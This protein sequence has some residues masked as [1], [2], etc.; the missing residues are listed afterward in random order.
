[1]IL[2]GIK[3]KPRKAQVMPNGSQT[4]SPR[5]KEVLHRKKLKHQQNRQHLT[6]E[7]W[8]TGKPGIGSRARASTFPVQLASGG[9][10]GRE[11]VEASEVYYF[12]SN[13]G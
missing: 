1:M 9:L 7:G 6:F 3:S 12:N 13:A 11:Q 4:L 2:A 10:A 8:L 5:E